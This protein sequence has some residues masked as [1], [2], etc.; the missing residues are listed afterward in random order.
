MEQ[1]AKKWFGGRVRRACLDL[2][3][4]QEEL[5]EILGISQ[6]VVWGIS[7]QCADFAQDDAFI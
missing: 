2:G 3:L 4:K 1:N 5:A 6:A 7:H